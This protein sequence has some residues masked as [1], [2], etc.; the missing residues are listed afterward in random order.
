MVAL[1][2]LEIVIETRNSYLSILKPKV[3]EG[4]NCVCFSK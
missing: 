3:M 4:K 2:S 1:D